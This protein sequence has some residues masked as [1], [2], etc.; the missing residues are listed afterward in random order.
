MT[1]VTLFNQHLSR[2]E[3][4]KTSISLEQ[5]S[6]L[7]V[8]CSLSPLSRKKENKPE[9]LLPCQVQGTKHNGSSSIKG[10]K[11]CINHQTETTCISGFL[12]SNL[13]VNIVYWFSITVFPVTFFSFSFSTLLF[14]SSS[15]SVMKG[16]YIT[17]YSKLDDLP[18][19]PNCSNTLGIIESAI[20]SI[21]VFV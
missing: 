13:A 19:K 18:P 15:P 20:N 16:N 14:I 10:I 17:F 5:L 3:T 4:I 8:C 1:Y 21:L 11:N 7:T 12:W 6:V 2:L 9:F